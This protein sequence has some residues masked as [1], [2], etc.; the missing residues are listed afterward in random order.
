ML[1]SIKETVVTL[2][3]FILTIYHRLSL[4]FQP[5][6]SIS[7]LNGEV[8]VFFLMYFLLF[9]KLIFAADLTADNRNYENPS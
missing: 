6:S 8:N 1:D 5:S 2:A 9:S 3:G 4:N 7:L